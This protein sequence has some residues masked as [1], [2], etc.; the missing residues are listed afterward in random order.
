MPRLLQLIVGRA[1]DHLGLQHRNGGVVQR[2]T[3]GTGRINIASCAVDGIRADDGRPEFRLY[4]CQGF[5]VQVC[6][7]DPGPFLVQVLA[8]IVA[9]M[10]NT[11]HSHRQAG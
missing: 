1:G 2:S 8:E 9:D 4:P 7:N 10:A 11:L 5:L 6:R 3:Q